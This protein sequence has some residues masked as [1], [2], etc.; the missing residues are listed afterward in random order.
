MALF[1]IV[2]SIT[3]GGI[4]G[5]LEV[6]ESNIIMRFVLTVLIMGGVMVPFMYIIETKT[7]WP[8]LSW[9]GMRRESK[10]E[11]RVR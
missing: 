2:V 9:A 10:Q 6:T 11:E 7:T 5:L 4:G 8:V 1:L 3:G